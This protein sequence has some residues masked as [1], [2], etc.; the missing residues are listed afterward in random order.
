MNRISKHI[1]ALFALF[2]CIS[3]YAGVEGLASLM[4]SGPVALT[5]SFRSRGDAPL[6]G[7][8]NLLYCD[9][10]FK[11]SGNGLE[12]YCDGRTI[13]T[14]DAGAKEIY[15]EE[16]AQA[17][18]FLA[19]PEKL[20]ESVSAFSMRGNSASGTYHVPSGQTVDFKLEGIHRPESLPSEWG[21][22][23]SALDRTWVVTDLR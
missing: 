17:N 8:G 18:H 22:D 2:C 20:S 23:T 21:F 12:I 19:S 10:R 16:A 13:W 15:I 1:S 5:Y 9:G 6:V 7:S 3:L 11:V 14:V 4:Q